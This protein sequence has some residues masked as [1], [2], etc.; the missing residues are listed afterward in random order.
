MVEDEVT[1]A[2]GCLKP[3]KS[4]ASGISTEVQLRLCEIIA[5]L[6]TAILRHG[7]VPKC[8]RDSVLVP[9]PKSGK[10][11]PSVTTIGQFFDSW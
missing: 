2:I 1:N 3:H 8:F 9:I 6:F 10:T 5:D 4:D 11:C 7:Y